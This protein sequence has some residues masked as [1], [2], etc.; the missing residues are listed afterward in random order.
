MAATFDLG[1]LTSILHVGGA[2]IRIPW[3]YVFFVFLL[4]A[5]LNAVNL[6]DGLTASRAA[7]S[8]W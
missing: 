2:T 1:V 7:A 6:T 8:S 3:L 4:M 5:G